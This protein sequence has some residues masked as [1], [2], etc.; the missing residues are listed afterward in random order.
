MLDHNWNQ[1]L[2]GFIWS[3]VYS[4]LCGNIALNWS[5]KL[6]WPKAFFLTNVGFVRFKIGT[7]WKISLSVIFTNKQPS[8]S[9]GAELLRDPCQ[10]LILQFRKIDRKFRINQYG[11]NFSSNEGNLWRLR[12]TNQYQSSANSISKYWH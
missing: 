10:F 2:L 11:N 12:K 3:F 7:I 5:N 8:T 1:G 4:Y 6:C 9:V